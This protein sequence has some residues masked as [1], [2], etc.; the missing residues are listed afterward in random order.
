MHVERVIHRALV[1]NLET[2][3]LTERQLHGWD[4][5]VSFAIDR[6]DLLNEPSP[7]VARGAPY[8][9]PTRGMADARTCCFH[10][11]NTTT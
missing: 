1:L 9:A 11:A 10:P 6:E 3:Y 5:R 2:P 7:N 8:A 4:V